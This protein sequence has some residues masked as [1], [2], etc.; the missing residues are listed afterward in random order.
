MTAI[1]RSKI[2]V[3][4]DEV[5]LALLYAEALDAAGYDTSL[6]SDSILAL[7]K[8]S[9]NLSQYMMV[10]SD[11]GMP[12]LNGLDLLTQ[13]HLKDDKIKFLLTSA[14]P[15]ISRRDLEF[16]F[17]E[18]PFRISLLLDTVRA[19]LKPEKSNLLVVET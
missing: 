5:E 3:V 4:D 8:I 10:I 7:E 19:I 9:L 6:F 15:Q 14:Y 17:L 13:I 2:A 1:P 16:T 12:G 18:K 11:N